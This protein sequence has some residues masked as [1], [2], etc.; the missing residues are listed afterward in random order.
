M[1]KELK[2][3]IG[4][5]IRLIRESREGTRPGRRRR[6]MTIEELADRAGLSV[7]Y[8]NKLELGHYQ[9]TAETLVRIGEALGV[10]VRELFPAE[11]GQGSPQKAQA[12]DEMRAVASR[13]S[14]SE[15]R[16]LSEVMRV[17]MKRP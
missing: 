10:D 16:Y 14:T 15:V 4:G 1:A 7:D 5:R 12:L 13:Y 3:A 17:V 11:A 9:P 6:R 8:V 2:H